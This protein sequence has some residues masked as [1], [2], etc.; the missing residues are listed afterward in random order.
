MISRREGIYVI[1]EGV[2]SE[3]FDIENIVAYIRAR[4][5]EECNKLLESSSFYRA[6]RDAGLSY[7][8]QFLRNAKELTQ[9]GG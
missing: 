1:R 8:M 6:G 9:A 2:L 5:Y 7:T 3:V 4:S